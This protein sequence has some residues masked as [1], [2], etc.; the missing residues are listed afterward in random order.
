MWMWGVLAAGVAGFVW[1]LRWILKWRDPS[2]DT[3]EGQAKAELWSTRIGSGGF[4][5]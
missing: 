2:W 5:A 3:Q 1:F 4:G